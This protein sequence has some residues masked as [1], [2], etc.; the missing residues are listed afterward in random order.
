ME[1]T[2]NILWPP[3]AQSVRNNAPWISHLIAEI[4]F[5]TCRLEMHATTDHRRV[6]A[7][8]AVWLLNLIVLHR[9]RSL[10][11][12]MIAHDS[13]PGV[14]GGRTYDT[15]IVF[16]S[17]FFSLVRNRTRAFSSAAQIVPMLQRWVYPCSQ[18]CLSC[19]RV[20]L[21]S[22]VVT[23]MTPNLIILALESNV[24]TVILQSDGFMVS[25][26]AKQVQSSGFTSSRATPFNAGET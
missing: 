7:R 8:G 19:P 11:V 3:G 15:E 18:R 14:S 6:T 26:S 16:F 20:L 9:N 5:P 12:S 4:T 17:L 22:C 13:I 25:V 10:S 1:K 24:L 23:A 2:S 21:E